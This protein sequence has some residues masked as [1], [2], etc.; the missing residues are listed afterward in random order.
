MKYIILM[1]TFLFSI[2]LFAAD[3][4]DWWLQRQIQ[5]G[6]G[7]N[8]YGKK[9]YGKAARAVMEDVPLA[10]G[11]GT[12]VEQLLKRSIAV[13][14]PTP[15]KV[16][17]SMLKRIYSPQAILGTAAVTGLLAAI[18]WVMEDG[19]YV[20]KYTDDENVPPNGYDYKLPDIGN[21]PFSTNF[22]WVDSPSKVVAQLE[23]LD[24]TKPWGNTK[25][26]RISN[27][28]LIK[29]GE[30]DYDLRYFEKFDGNTSGSTYTLR[31]PKRISPVPQP[32]PDVITVPL[33]A[34]LLG[35]AM[36]GEGYKDPDPKFDN[37]RVNTGHDTGV[38]EIYEH[39][40]SGIG[41]ELADVMDDK[42]K[43]AKPTDDGQPSYVGDPKY[44]GRP[45]GDD[46]DDLSDR[47]WDEKGDEATGTTEPTK[48][49]ETGEA[50]G[51]QSI[52]LQFPLFCSWASKM[53]QWYDDWKASD[54]VHQK[55]EEDV[56]NHQT[57]E[58]SFWQ[59]VKDWFDWTKEEPEPEPDE[60]Q[61]EPDDQ[62]IFTRTF[63]TAFSLSKECPPDIPYSFETQ[64][65]SGS[66]NLNMGWL[67]LIFTTL[68][69]P[70]VF[71]SHCIGMWILYETAIRKQ[72]KW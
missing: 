34:A 5:I 31:L 62:G 9:V 55:F 54:K 50:T 42:L 20:K 10:D 51:G 41:D 70:L 21:Q 7:K 18:G 32:E 44:D 27:V 29:V 26:I 14:K 61:P 25:V 37:D 64:Y 38:K 36:L 2:Q 49:P 6:D 1:L 56:K 22:P 17:S 30:F 69:Y 65:F 57:E 40:P 52:S 35:A 33:T 71:A 39:D 24:G 59:T 60:Q 19:V 8:Q 11:T 15:S 46:R 4:G 53:C 3:D 23:G 12:R 16:G 68:S 28:T 67:C 47:S 63:D 58:K 43:N 13:D 66:F 72:I 45:L 48:D